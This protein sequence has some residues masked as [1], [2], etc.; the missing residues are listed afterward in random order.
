MSEK[1]G[2]GCLIAA[3]VGAALVS[4]AGCG[5]FNVVPPGHRGVR[6]TLGSVSE[7]VLGE[8]VAVKCPIISSIILVPI[9]Q[10]TTEGQAECYSSDLQQIKVRYAVLYRIP[11]KNVVMLYQQYKGD[12]FASLVEPRLQD[13][14]KQALSKSTAENTIKSRDQIKPKVLELLRAELG[15]L[16]DVI[17]IPIKDAELTPQLEKAIEEKQVQQQQALAKVYELEKA[18]KDKEIAIVVAQA[19]AESV[20]IKGEALKA[21]PEVIQLEIAKKWNGVS[22]LYVSTTEGGANVMLPLK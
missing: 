18:Q 12:P 22:P 7:G 11:E 8:G 10:M 14:M 13:A 16:V 1:N 20:R 19:E 4:I 3:L 21:S 2:Y 9:Q 5:T 17:D 15:G 6:V